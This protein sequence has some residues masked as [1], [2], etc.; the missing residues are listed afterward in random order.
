MITASNLQAAIKRVDPGL[1]KG[2]RGFLLIDRL[3]DIA[4]ALSVI[5]GDSCQDC[6]H[7]LTEDSAAW[8]DG[9]Y[10]CRPC[11]INATTNADRAEPSAPFV[12]GG[13]RVIR[14]TGGLS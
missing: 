12:G 10:L 2:Q 9:R 14:K 1:L 7:A 11:A 4:M 3:P 13:V 6:G 5:M 8:V